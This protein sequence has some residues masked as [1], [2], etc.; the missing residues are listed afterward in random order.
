MRAPISA[1]CGAVVPRIFVFIFI[2]FIV[3]SVES[4]SDNATVSTDENNT[5]NTTES[6][7]TNATSDEIAT[8]VNVSEENVTEQE[9]VITVGPVKLP[10]DVEI[11]RYKAEEAINTSKLEL[12]SVKNYVKTV[13]GMLDLTE[14]FKLIDKAGIM[15]SKAIN[16]FQMAEDFDDMTL[17]KGFFILAKSQAE[18]SIK[19][20]HDARDLI[21]KIYMAAQEERKKR[22]DTEKQIKA[23][24]ALIKSIEKLLDETINI[25]SKAKT[26]GFNILNSQ[27]KIDEAEVLLD[28]AKI[29]L[30]NA[31]RYF[32]E[33]RYDKALQSVD[34]ATSDALDVQTNLK[35]AQRIVVSSAN[36]EEKMGEIIKRQID[37][38]T[39]ITEKAYNYLNRINELFKYFR[40]LGLETGIYEED[41]RKSVNYYSA[42]NTA[43]TAAINR[44]DANLQDIAQERSLVALD[45]AEQAMKLSGVILTDMT[46]ELKKLLGQKIKMARE[47]LAEFSDFYANLNITLSDIDELTVERNIYR[48]NRMI[49]EAED[50]RAN[51]SPDN[52]DVFEFR[53]VLNKTSS[54]VILIGNTYRYVERLIASEKAVYRDLIYINKSIEKINES[55][56]HAEAM[57]VVKDQRDYLKKIIRL[58]KEAEELY[59]ESDYISAEK[60]TLQAVNDTRIL[61]IVA[62]QMKNATEN[63]KA[64]MREY[65]ALEIEAKKTFSGVKRSDLIDIEAEMERSKQSIFDRNYNRTY[66]LTKQLRE[67]IRDINKRSEEIR[68]A[69]LRFFVL[70]LFTIFLFAITALYEHGIFIAQKSQTGLERE[71]II[72]E[73]EIEQW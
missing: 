19:Y 60:I 69:K 70:I 37:T 72:S 9:S 35:L 44:L 29:T 59:K 18:E 26:E 23:A 38:A 8:T 61:S 24:Y 20:S 30:Q 71:E 22:S 10:P 17:K 48:A 34:Q 62:E 14:P 28:T 58:Y 68:D 43:I 57:I 4:L 15:L 11:V 1:N 66:Y 2:L 63:L 16:S 67:K 36:M 3:I 49:I 41:W 54:A 12:E 50:Y 27:S 73:F 6:V 25:V 31:E 7:E 53:D 64:V 5:L 55:L 47:S 65:K 32:N 51:L 42:A 13:P 52:I 39:N 56:N 40:R 21:D 45:N 46:D 33:S